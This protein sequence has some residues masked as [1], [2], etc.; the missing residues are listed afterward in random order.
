MKLENLPDEIID[1]IKAEMFFSDIRVIKAYP[2][3]AA[4]VRI[5][6]ETIAIGIDEITMM[7]ASMDDSRRKGD[8]KI[9]ADIFIPIKHGSSRAG[10]IF[11]K[12][13]SCLKKYNVVSIC[14]QRIA[15]DKRTCSYIMKTAIAFNDE[16]EVV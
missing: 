15:V 14:A 6:R 5:S 1:L 16:I 10:E 8:I 2:C 3:D 11:I 9:F 4:S 7:S 13:C 12:L